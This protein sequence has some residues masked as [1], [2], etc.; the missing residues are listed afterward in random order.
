MD[1]A[2]TWRF[3]QDQYVLAFRE[4]KIPVASVFFLNFRDL[5]STGKFLGIRAAGT[6]SN[7]PAGAFITKASMTLYPDGAEP[8]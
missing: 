5:R 8:A 1:L 3:A 2:T 4:F 7:E 6:V